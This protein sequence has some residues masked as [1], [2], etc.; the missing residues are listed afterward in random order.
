MPHRFRYHRNAN[1]T[2]MAN[3]LAGENIPLPA[4]GSFAD[5]L[6]LRATGAKMSVGDGGA[7]VVVSVL[8]ANTATAAGFEAALAAQNVA[9]LANATGGAAVGFRAKHEAWWA[10]K[11]ANHWVHISTPAAPA[12]GERL[13][14]M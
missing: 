13:S 12:D 4:A 1:S 2:Y 5:P 7:V 10:A 14:M 11:W 3:T 6:H 9:A 8:T